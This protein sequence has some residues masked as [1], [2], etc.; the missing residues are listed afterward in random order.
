MRTVN[1]R[2]PRLLIAVD[3]PSVVGGAEAWAASAIAGLAA[4]GWDVAI[5]HE[6]P[7]TP[8]RRPITEGVQ[9][10]PGSEVVLGRVF[11]GLPG[12]KPNAGHLT[13]LPAGKHRVG[14][15]GVLPPP[16][17]VPPSNA[18]QPGSRYCPELRTG[19]L[20]VELRSAK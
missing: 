8:D 3:S 6:R 2:C 20:D 10:N 1:S 4:R 12:A 7:P 16:E 18:L 15:E 19:Y 14:S 9:L 11:L 5:L 13:E 17:L